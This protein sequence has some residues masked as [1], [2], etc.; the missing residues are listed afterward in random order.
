VVAVTLPRY[1]V[2]LAIGGVHGYHPCVYLPTQEPVVHYMQA[3]V[4]HHAV[5][6]F[7]H[8]MLSHG[9]S[10]RYGQVACPFS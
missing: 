5:H 2:Y 1:H 10:S 3:V 6:Q 7:L 8:F 4:A 9:R